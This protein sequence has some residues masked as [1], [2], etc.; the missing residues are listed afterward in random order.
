MSPNGALLV[1][2]GCPGGSA[3]KKAVR[4]RHGTW[5]AGAAL[6]LLATGCIS[7]NVGPPKTMEETRI[8]V[9]EATV[10]TRE[11]AIAVRAT[12][13]APTTQSVLIGLEGDVRAEYSRTSRAVTTSRSE[14]RR[15]AF[16]LF[17]GAAE[18]FGLPSGAEKRSCTKPNYPTAFFFGALPAGLFVGLG[19]VRALVW[20][21]PCGSYDCWKEQKTEAYSHVGLVGFHKYT[22]FISH[23]PVT[24]PERPEE[25]N[26]VT[27]PHV[28]A[29]GPYSVE[30]RIPGLGHYD[31]KSV[32][33]GETSVSF[34]LPEV[35]RDCA[36][37]ASAVFR[38]LPGH[39][40]GDAVSAR[41]LEKTEGRPLNFTL[42]LHA[43]PDAP[44]TPSYEI[45][46]VRPLAD[47][48]YVVRAAI[49]DPSATF[50]VA[51]EVEREVRRQI[52]ADY[53][54]KHPE[55]AS[56]NV[57]ETIQ[58]QTEGDGRIL[59]F[60]AWAFS[61]QPVADGWTYNAYTH[62]G[63]VRL[64]LSGGMPPEEAKRWARENIEAI[65][66]EKNVLLR[67]GSP[68]PDGAAY[69]SLREEF[70]DG[71]LAVEFE[72]TE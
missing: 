70:R 22:V 16:G 8:L 15:L 27:T 64:R 5:W 71:V 45:L 11:E 10:P 44:E 4:Q 66:R 12:H 29:A 33:A 48:K 32:G 21:L 61:I 69:R 43:S 67:A 19:T 37:E 30:F 23:K 49:R 54:G 34:P 38:R 59:V 18:E 57:R 2:C 26:F 42:Y 51:R 20:E 14:Q 68:V 40:P 46:S 52:R 63:T 28:K 17:P 41:L 7:V 55:A 58:W 60:T 13:T 47:G 65:A 53:L 50:R 25:S 56:G 9:E 1:S 31:R 35:S 3:W 24:G 72:A 36:E 62:R 39:P 6:A